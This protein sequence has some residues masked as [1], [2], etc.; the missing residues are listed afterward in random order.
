[1]HSLLLLVN[2]T[3]YVIIL[4]HFMPNENVLANA[5]PAAF[6]GG[7]AL[8][9]R[10]KRQ[11]EDGEAEGEEGGGDDAEGAEEDAEGG[12]DEEKADEDEAKE[13]GDGDEGEDKEDKAE[14]ED[15]DGDGD[16]KDDEED[17][18]KE[19]E[20]KDK[21]GKGKGGDENGNGNGGGGVPQPPSAGGDG[22]CTDKGTGCEEGFCSNI[23][24][25]R[26]HCAGTCKSHLEE[27][28]HLASVSDITKS[29]SDTG[30]NCGT[31]PDICTDDNLAVCGCAHTCNR[32]HHQASY[33]AQG[34]CKN[35]Q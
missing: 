32:C 19:G 23:E 28:S 5:I 10:K 16:G 31:I 4:L 26:A 24:F 6:N 2:I 29:C 27:C 11:D 20:D 7:D 34:M 30:T 21:G 17:D 1:M 25:A 35:V 33:M 15:G 18:E 12:E 14:D 13:D 8:L 9:L 22:T 3:V